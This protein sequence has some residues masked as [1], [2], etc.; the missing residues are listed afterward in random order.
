MEWHFEKGMSWDNW[1]EV[2]EIDHIIPLASFDLND[3]DQ[4]LIAVHYTNLQP[5]TVTENRQKGDKLDW[6]NKE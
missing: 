6:V 5:L 1:G 3:R 2:W 4:L